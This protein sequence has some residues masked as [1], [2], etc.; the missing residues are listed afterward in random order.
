MRSGKYLL[1]VCFVALALLP[2]HS[3]VAK[4]SRD[5]MLLDRVA[6]VVN[7]EVITLSEVQAA[8]AHMIEGLPGDIDRQ[9]ARIE[10]LT[11]ALGALI[12]ERLLEQETRARQI[13][14][15]EAEIDRAIVEVRRQHGLTDSQFRQAIAA[16]GYSWEA[17]RQELA[18][19]LERY[20]LLGAEVQARVEITDEDVRSHLARQG[21]RREVEEARVRHILVRIPEA[22]TE[23]ELED[24]RRHAESIFERAVG[25]EDF[26][27]LAREESE[28]GSARTGGDLGWLQR[29]RMVKALDEAVFEAEEGEI[30]GPVRSPSGFHVVQVSERRTTRAEQ[31]EMME[32][33]ARQTL[34][35]EALESETQ[36]F[37]E[38]L[39]RRA[40]IEF[41]IPEISS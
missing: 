13:H 27:D 26:G 14:V 3:V 33:R 7:G 8:A 16:Q 19:Q 30:L 10:A 29:G 5:E 38:G 25:G 41:K 36:R 9:A 15:T 12:D 24:L 23:P 32:H 28:D 4:E 22:A 20:K 31:D 1:N 35:E 11:E 6:A 21:A 2:I 17:Y 39:R 34:M 18:G 37:I 40:V